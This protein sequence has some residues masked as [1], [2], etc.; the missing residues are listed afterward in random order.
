MIINL[1]NK[2]I[3]TDTLSNQFLLSLNQLRFNLLKRIFLGYKN[4][5]LIIETKSC[6]SMSSKLYCSNVPR[7]WSFVSIK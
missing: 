2:L 1:N 3:K 5:S 4:T 6:L 7:S